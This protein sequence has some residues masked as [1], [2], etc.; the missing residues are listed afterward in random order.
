MARSLVALLVA[1]PL[2]LAACSSKGLPP[3]EVQAWVGRPVERLRQEWGAPTRVIPDGDLSLH[4]YE[5]LERRTTR[6]FTQQDTQ[7][8]LA[9]DDVGARYRV[10]AYRTPS[11]YVRAY[12]FWAD[13][14]GRIVRA[15]IHEP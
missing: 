12:R 2:L 6:T 10:E 3:E 14:A 15:E 7:V 9:R 5:E 13:P 8:Q 11:V 1:A 4:V